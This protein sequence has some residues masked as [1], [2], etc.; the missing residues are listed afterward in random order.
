MK[1]KLILLT[2]VLTAII[3]TACGGQQTN[4]SQDAGNDTGL[5]QI[6]MAYTQAAETFAAEIALTEAA[7]P[8]ATNT[9]MSS[10]TPVI[11]ATN[12][13][14]PDQASPTPFPTLPPLASPTPFPTQS[15]GTVAGRPCL[16]AELLWESPQ[17]GKVLSPGQSFLKEWRFANSGDCT[18]TG[19]F[20]LV[21][22]DG[23]NFGDVTLYNLVDV[24]DIGDAGVPNGNRLIITMSFQAPDSPGH[25]V[26]YYMLAEPNGNLFGVGPLGNE[27]FWVDIIVRD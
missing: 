3:L 14:L 22:T 21:L 16:R 10:P 1:N 18:W 27:R 13:P 24:S 25:Y 20:R 11:L 7:K 26:G 6:D 17:D 2:I 8:S 4:G 12:T 5:S 15:S 19:D 9:P 23:T